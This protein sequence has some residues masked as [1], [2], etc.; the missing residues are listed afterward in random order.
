MTLRLTITPI[1]T[2][3]PPFVYLQT[4]TLHAHD[5]AIRVSIISIYD[6]RVSC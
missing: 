2:P 6:T 5:D 3:T 4:D 1:I